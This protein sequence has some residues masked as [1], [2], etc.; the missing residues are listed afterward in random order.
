MRLNMDHLSLVQ[1]VVT[2]IRMFPTNEQEEVLEPGPPPS[3]KRTSNP[4]LDSRTSFL[5]GVDWPHL[6]TTRT[7]YFDAPRFSRTQ[8]W[9]YELSR[10]QHISRC[11][12]RWPSPSFFQRAQTN[13]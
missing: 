2:L 11:I 9:R 6:Q 12:F 13:G 1:I 4:N 7:T 3:L 10:S 8:A 5:P